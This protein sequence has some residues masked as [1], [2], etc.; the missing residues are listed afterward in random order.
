MSCIR[1]RSVRTEVKVVWKTVTKIRHLTSRCL[2]TTLSFMKST[3]VLQ[4]IWWGRWGYHTQSSGLGCTTTSQTDPPQWLHLL[5]SKWRP[6]HLKLKLSLSQ[7]VGCTSEVVQPGTSVH[8]GWVARDWRTFCHLG[9]KSAGTLCSP[10]QMSVL[11]VLSLLYTDGLNF[12][13]KGGNSMSE[14][15]LF[16]VMN[17]LYKLF[18]HITYWRDVSWMCSTFEEKLRCAENKRIST[19]EME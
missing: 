6:W 9:S 4:F 18:I 13:S 12:W 2:E 3:S 19:H 7:K 16:S 1:P 17:G 11:I 15:E 5:G 8:L 10:A 14:I